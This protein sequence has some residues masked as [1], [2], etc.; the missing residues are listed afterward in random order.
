MDQQKTA[1]KTV[2]KTAA[3]V[4]LQA[5]GKTAGQTDNLPTEISRQ[6]AN[7]AVRRLK[8]VKQ[9][10]TDR[11]VEPDISFFRSAGKF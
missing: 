6:T 3:E 10:K 4:S 1:L 9:M 8:T 11:S 5:M 7:K 2:R